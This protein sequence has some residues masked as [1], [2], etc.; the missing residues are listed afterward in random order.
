MTTF[1][2]SFKQG[3][4]QCLT[5]QIYRHICCSSCSSQLEKKSFL[6]LAS[7]KKQGRSN[8]IYLYFSFSTLWR[9]LKERKVAQQFCVPSIRKWLGKWA[10]LVRR[11]IVTAITAGLL[12]MKIVYRIECWTVQSFFWDGR[13]QS[14]NSINYCYIQF[15]IVRFFGFLSLGQRT[16]V[17]ILTSFV[18]GI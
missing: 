16:I 8:V 10:L 6:S 15:N 11:F 4:Q 5:W 7:M 3:Y 9:R 18:E 13:I 12:K 1:Y 14:G 2:H 17:F